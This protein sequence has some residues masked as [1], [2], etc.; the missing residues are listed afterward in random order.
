MK[1]ISLLL[2]GGFGLWY[3]LRKGSA[4]NQLKWNIVGIN[5]AK[6]AL[7][8]ELINATN[9]PL[10]FSALVADVKANGSPVGLI[11]FRKQTIIPATG[12]V[13]IDVPLKL[14]ALG[15]LQFVSSGLKK[16]KTLEF[17]GTLNAENLSIPFVETL[18]FNTANA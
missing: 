4:G 9:T 1:N 5:A 13:K 15:V 6:R 2:L 8:I 12:G 7:Q 17:D 16:I 10:K 18:N 14:N 11:D 3:L